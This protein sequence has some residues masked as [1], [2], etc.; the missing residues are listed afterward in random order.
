MVVLE[1]SLSLPD[2]SS[3]DLFDL[4]QDLYLLSINVNVY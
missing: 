4:K 1:V 3:L 2:P